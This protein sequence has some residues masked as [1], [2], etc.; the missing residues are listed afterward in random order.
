[1]EQWL[2]EGILRG[3]KKKKEKNPSEQFS[4]AYVPKTSSMS[5]CINYME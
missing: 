3:K 5:K 1:M 4:E 2:S